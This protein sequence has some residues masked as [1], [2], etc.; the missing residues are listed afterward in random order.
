MMKIAFL[1]GLI[2]AIFLLAGC[3]SAVE[4]S[5]AGPR[6]SDDLVQVPEGYS[7]TATTNR[8]EGADIES[9]KKPGIRTQTKY[10]K[11][12]NSRVDTLFKNKEKRNYRIV[13]GNSLIIHECNK[14]NEKWVCDKVDSIPW[15]PEDIGEGY[16][17]T[18]AEWVQGQLGGTSVEQ[19]ADRKIAGVKAKCFSYEGG[20]ISDISCF[21]PTTTIRLYHKSKGYTMKVTSLDLNVPD[22][23]LFVVP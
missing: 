18:I 20:D 17:G 7:L 5:L 6:A 19:T 16:Q 15:T 14:E 21:H 10:V 22:D 11:K 3:K 23:K 9:T 12:D 8:L 2:I 13:E 1:L 4:E